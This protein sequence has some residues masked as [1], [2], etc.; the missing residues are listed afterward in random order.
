MWV[1][2]PHRC[3]RDEDILTE[4][5]LQDR[6]DSLH[7][8]RGTTTVDVDKPA[9]HPVAVFVGRPGHPYRVGPGADR[10]RHLVRDA[11]ADGR[12]VRLAHRGQHLDEWHLF[13]VGKAP[14]VDE[15]LGIRRITGVPMRRLGLAPTCVELVIGI[16]SAVCGALVL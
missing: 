5:A 10:T 14:P 6:S 3:D 12:R 9:R 13:T 11:R 15:V 4:D 2:R 16:A 1:Y 8:I 7:L